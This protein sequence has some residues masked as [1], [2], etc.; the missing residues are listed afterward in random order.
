MNSSKSSQMLLITRW[1]KVPAMNEY[2]DLTTE[3]IKYTLPDVL[4]P[5]YVVYDDQF[6]WNYNQGGLKVNLDKDQ[7]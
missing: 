1:Y 6:G 4:S 7:N 2:R 3:L 5:W